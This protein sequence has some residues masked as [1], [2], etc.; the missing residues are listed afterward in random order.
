M[1]AFSRCSPSDRPLLDP[2]SPVAR[3]MVLD[4][5]CFERESNPQCASDGGAVDLV[6][7][8]HL[9]VF[10]KRGGQQRHSHRSTIE[11]EQVLERGIRGG[12]GRVLFAAER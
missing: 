6:R 8:T 1:P 3:P 4:P 9:L 7:A 5:P 2:D 11:S 10:Q 12:D